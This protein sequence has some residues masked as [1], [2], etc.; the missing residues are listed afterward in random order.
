VQL[1]GLTVVGLI[2][3]LL[4]LNTEQSDP[5]C[6]GAGSGRCFL[7]LPPNSGESVPPGRGTSTVR[8]LLPHQELYASEICIS[9]LSV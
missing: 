3:S 6:G 8:F 5:L 2:T 4:L 1:E 7:H 9:Y